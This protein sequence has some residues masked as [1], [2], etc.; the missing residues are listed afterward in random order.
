MNTHPGRRVGLVILGLLSLGDMSAIL[1]T[2]GET[3]PYAVA[4]AALV[5]GLVSLVLVVRA[6]RRPSG[7]LRLLIGLRILSAVLAIPAFFAPD[8]PVGAQAAA[9]AVVVLTAV[10]VVLTARGGSLAV[11][12]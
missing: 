12:S 6:Y 1:L 10:G 9:A 8:V 2:D 3:P 4:A 5:L 7:S 11:A